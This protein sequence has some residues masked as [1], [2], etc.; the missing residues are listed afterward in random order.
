MGYASSIIRQLPP[1][2][3]ADFPAVLTHRS[4]FSKQLVRLLRT[5]FQNAAGPHRMHQIL[6]TNHTEKFDSIQFQYYDALKDKL[7]EQKMAKKLVGNVSTATTYPEF[8]T[9]NDR[10]G[11]NGYVPSANYISYVYCSIIDELRPYMNHHTS[12]L[13]GIVLKGDHSF[14]VC[15]H[16]NSYPNNTGQQLIF[17]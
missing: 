11:Y 16:Q 3:Q 15:T 1:R 14:K 7:D 13:D 12:L 2:V 4:G 10:N 5:Q 6:R 9:F 17:F 8:S